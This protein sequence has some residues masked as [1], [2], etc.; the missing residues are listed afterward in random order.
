MKN[1][2]LS[3]LKQ[4][5]GSFV[6]LCFPPLCLDCQGPLRKTERHFCANCQALL[7]LIDIESRC[8]KCFS[9]DYCAQR[10][11]CVGCSRKSFPFVQLGAAFEHIGPAAT[12][13]QKMK[14]S[15]QP[16]LAKSAA[17]FL[18]I[19]FFALKWPMPD[20]IVPVPV[21]LVRL[22]QRGYNQSYE[23]GLGLS[24]YLNCPVQNILKRQSSGYSQAGL[25]HEHRIALKPSL[26][27]LKKNAHIQ[28]QII[29]L[30]DDVTTT[31]TTLFCCAETLLEQCPKAIYALT[32][33]RA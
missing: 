13:V 9:S 19:Q 8:P 7:E 27:S 23:L 16:Y 3:V 18:A 17:A 14:Y 28:D 24:E 32:L 33:T 11:L 20:L 26:F 21:S 6:D 12:L 5:A 31:G 29:L 22:F 30:V 4:F 10:R 25:A 1:R 2:Y 15:G